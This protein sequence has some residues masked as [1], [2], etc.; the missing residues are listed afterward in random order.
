MVADEHPSGLDAQEIER[1][2][3]AFIERELLGPGAT[4]GPDDNLL[5]GDLLD[6]MG[7]LRLAAFVAEEFRFAIPPGDFVVANFRN[8]S[9]LS[10]YVHRMVAGAAGPPGNAAR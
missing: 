4:V 2:I 9:V 10:G 7:V 5:S 3:A 6:S 8:V 1:R